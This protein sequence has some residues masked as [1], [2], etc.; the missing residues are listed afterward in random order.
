MGI[1]DELAVELREAIKSRDV[2]RRDVIRQVETEARTTAAQR[3]AGPMDD[4]FYRSVLASYVKRM[5]K[6]RS[7][8]AEFGQRG[9]AM[10]DKLA[11]E[12]KY[13]SRWLPVKLGEEET[14]RL[15]LEAIGEL[16][17]AG[18]AS[19]AGRVVGR[20]M[21]DRQEGLDGALVNR[22]ARQELGP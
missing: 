18:D 2:W 10:A 9:A 15:V 7:E 11:F 6:A 4:D 16:G 22:L 14:R 12:V 1:K 20:V 5:D 3:D 8:Y 17:V 13:L 21:G 19:A